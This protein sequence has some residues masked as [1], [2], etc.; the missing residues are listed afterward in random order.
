MS[1][2]K[3]YCQFNSAFPW[4][5]YVRFR[6]FSV[7]VHFQSIYSSKTLAFR[8]I[9]RLYYF[10]IVHLYCWW[11]IF[12]VSTHKIHAVP[13]VNLNNNKKNERRNA[14]VFTVFSYNPASKNDGNFFILTFC[15]CRMW[16]LKQKHTFHVQKSCRNFI[17]D[18][19][20]FLMSQT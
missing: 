6:H 15:I 12:L 18:K 13:E 20:L 3:I 5:K 8:K 4:F 17:R 2:P 11:L 16:H 10:Y 9:K 19:T 1:S 14:C 7:F